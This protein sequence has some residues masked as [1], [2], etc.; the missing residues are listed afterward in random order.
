MPTLCQPIPTGLDPA[1][2]GA[3]PRVSAVFHTSRGAHLP[4]PTTAL[5]PLT[6]NQFCGAVVI[7]TP[8]IGCG[9][10]VIRPPSRVP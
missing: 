2:D 3:D 7:E 8:D 6:A 5:L 1:R 9:V 10:G 4:L